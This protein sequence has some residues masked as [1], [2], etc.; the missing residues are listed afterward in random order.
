[1]RKTILLL[2]LLAHGAILSAQSKK[3]GDYIESYSFNEPTN[4]GARETQYVPVD[5]D[6]LCVN[7]KNRYTRALYGSNTDYRVETSDKPIFALFKAKNYCNVRFYIDGVQLDSVAYCEARYG[8]GRRSYLLRDKRWGDNAELRI[9]CVAMPDA[10]GVYW[11]FLAKDFAAKEV[12]LRSK[13]CRTVAKKLSRNGDIGA[14]KPGCFEP[15]PTEEGL[16]EKSLTFRSEAMAVSTPYAEKEKGHT[17]SLQLVTADVLAKYTA[18]KKHFETLAERVV[19]HTPDP[20]FNTL[21]S[22]LA[23]AADGVWDG[24]T[25]LHGAI[26]WRMPLAGWR[27]GYLGDVL[28]WNDRAVSHF[29]AYANSQVTDVSATIP[30]PSQDP[31]MNLARA[32]KK[33]GTQMYSNGYICR[34]PNRNDQMHHYD[35]NLNYIDELLWHFQYD[36]DT[37]YMR[38]M[39]P[40]I[41][42]HLA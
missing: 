41:T 35:M 9:E 14:D 11:Y 39:W 12:V 42:S 15:S 38:R 21:G 2:L 31:A 27:A 36:A 13:I 34:N 4:R 7:G 10:E 23:L 24:E 28:G 40:V 25:W 17:L 5:G 20:V 8:K 30:S 19:F 37:A 32:E 29:N 6:F 16:V 26:G 3:I 33:W 18:S 22:T 1:M